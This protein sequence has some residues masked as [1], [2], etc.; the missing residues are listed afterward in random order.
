MLCF[1][2]IGSMPISSIETMEDLLERGRHTLEQ[3]LCIQAG[4]LR[5]STKRPFC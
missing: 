2:P 4:T 5:S 3:T 1:G